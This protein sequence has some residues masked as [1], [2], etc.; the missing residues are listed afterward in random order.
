MNLEKFKKQLIIDEGVKYEIYFDHLGFPTFGIGHLLTK[1]D[2]EWDIYSRSNLPLLSRVIRGFSGYNKIPKSIIDGFPTWDKIN[3]S[4]ERVDEVFEKDIK[5]VLD[6]CKKLFNDFDEYLD[7]VKQIIA[8]MMFNL[9][10]TRLSKFK[11]FCKAIKDKN[12]KK[13]SLEMVDSA[14][15]RQVPNRAKRLVKRMEN[16]ANEQ[17]CEIK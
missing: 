9:G 8:N 10:L 17:L 2:V 15:Y 4:K 7:E 5:I 6:D 3:I 16:L 1:K 11:N 14:W 12:Y 13:A